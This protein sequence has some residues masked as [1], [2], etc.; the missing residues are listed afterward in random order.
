MALKIVLGEVLAAPEEAIFSSG[1]SQ[2]VFVDKGN[3]MFEPRH[4]VLGKHA[5]PFYEIKQ[6]LEEG[7]RVITNGNFLV[8][9][10]SRLKAALSN[11]GSKE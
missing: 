11:M 8:D 4:V 6:G 10:E 3:G 5:S 2:L 9:S 7:E 1:A